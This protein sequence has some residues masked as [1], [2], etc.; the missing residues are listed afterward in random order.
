MIR[1]DIAR[2]NKLGPA[3]TVRMRNLVVY[4]IR[5]PNAG[6]KIGFTRSLKERLQALLAEYGPPIDVLGII[7]GGRAKEREMHER[8]AAYRIEGIERFRESSEMIVFIRSEALSYQVRKYGCRRGGY[9]RHA[10]RRSTYV[11]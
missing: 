1:S 3:N 11:H 6:I 2:L 10:P 5:L 7:D 4:F 8:F 9:R